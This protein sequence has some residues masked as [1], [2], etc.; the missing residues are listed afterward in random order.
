MHDHGMDVAR[1][2][3][4]VNALGPELVP[5]RLATALRALSPADL[6]GFCD[7][8]A[9][10]EDELDTTEHRASAHTAFELDPSGVR[11]RAWTAGSEQRPAQ[12]DELQATVVAHGLDAW[13]A[14]VAV[15]PLLSGGWPTGL[16]RQV[17]L[18][19]ADAVRR[20]FPEPATA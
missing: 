2:W 10:A 1:F 6:G 12:F 17:L 16:G 4:V 7:R 13:R 15:P 3:S 18:A 5:A 11:L 9:D 20:A 19:V 14:V 8:L